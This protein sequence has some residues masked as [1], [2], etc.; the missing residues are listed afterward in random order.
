MTSGP[1]R[2]ERLE[3]D[4]LEG[5]LDAALLFLFVRRIEVVAARYLVIEQGEV[6]VQRFF[7]ELLLVQSPSELVERE[8]VV[9]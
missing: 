4:D 5:I 1:P 3:A 8:L 9:L 7:V 6:P 2:F